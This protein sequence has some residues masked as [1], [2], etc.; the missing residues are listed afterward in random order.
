ME[1]GWWALDMHPAQVHGVSLVTVSGRSLDKLPKR[2]LVF[3][4]AAAM[5]N[6]F[7][8]VDCI[9]SV[10][11]ESCSVRCD[12]LWHAELVGDELGPLDVPSTLESSDE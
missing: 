8:N 6:A 9:S 3:G 1:L 12:Q 10:R 4:A 7:R 2:L 11:T 5:R